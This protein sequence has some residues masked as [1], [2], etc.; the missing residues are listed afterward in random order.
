MCI[1]LQSYNFCGGMCHVEAHPTRRRYGG[2]GRKKFVTK[3]FLTILGCSP[4]L[5]LRSMVIVKME[6]KDDDREY[7]TK[8]AVWIG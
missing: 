1:Y 2:P 5:W 6:P 4:I 8:R 7:R 3:K